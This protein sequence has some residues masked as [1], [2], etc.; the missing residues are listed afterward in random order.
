MKDI[1]REVREGIALENQCLKK[2]D[3]LRNELIP[4]YGNLT[5]K[6]VEESLW[7]QYLKFHNKVTNYF[8]DE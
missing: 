6:E 3:F 1:E 8:K 4:V 2:L 7:N 5:L